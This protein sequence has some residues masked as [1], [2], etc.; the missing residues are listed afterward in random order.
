ML[1]QKRLPINVMAAHVLVHL[2]VLALSELRFSSGGGFSF[3]L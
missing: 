3:F 2:I 1:Q